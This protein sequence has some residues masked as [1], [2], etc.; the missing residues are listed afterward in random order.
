MDMLLI[1]VFF[2]AWILSVAKLESILSHVEFGFGRY[3]GFF[4]SISD[5][6]KQNEFVEQTA[7]SLSV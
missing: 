3:D 1:C 4:S 7:F 6:V 2:V 5:R